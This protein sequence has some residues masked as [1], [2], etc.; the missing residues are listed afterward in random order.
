MPLIIVD[1]P[2]KAG[3]TTLCQAMASYYGYTVR[4]WGP[5]G[6]QV[7]NDVAFLEQLK[8][9]VVASWYYD[10][11]IIWD[12]CWASEAVYGKLLGRSSRLSSDWWL[13]EWLYGR[14]VQTAGL[15]VILAGPPPS[16]LQ[17][18]RDST[19]LPVDPKQEQDAYLEYGK[20]FGWTMLGEYTSSRTLEE[21]DYAALTKVRRELSTAPAYAGK[22]EASVIAVGLVRNSISRFPGSWLPF[23]TAMT[24]EYGR[25]LGSD[26]FKIGWTNMGDVDLK[27]MPSV[28]RVLACG[29][30]AESWVRHNKTQSQD[31][32]SLP[33]PAA[34]MR[35]GR[36]PADE[37]A[38]VL[39]NL[40]QAI[41]I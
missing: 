20:A 26:A 17:M 24:M 1:G 16:T 39:D 34:L 18:R 35:W 2:E 41:K 33:H 36:Y 23:T 9:D 22:S 31:I 40:K 21:L 29:R 4:H 38:R 12:R 19:D 11:K 15:R 8:A 27:A 30:Q 3:K 5:L 28:K 7:A 10:Q 13:G 32:V 25:A 6:R 14:A 37:R